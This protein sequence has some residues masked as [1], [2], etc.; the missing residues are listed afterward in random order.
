MIANNEIN[1]A[2]RRFTAKLDNVI[3]IARGT[4]NTVLNPCAVVGYVPLI[5]LPYDK[6][7]LSTLEGIALGSEG[8]GAAVGI[9]L[10]YMLAAVQ[11]RKK[12]RQRQKERQKTDDL[13]P[14]FD[15]LNDEPIPIRE[16]IERLP[17]QIAVIK[18]GG[19]RKLSFMDQFDAAIDKRPIFNEPG[20]AELITQRNVQIFLTVGAI[21]AIV[22]GMKPHQ[23]FF[24]SDNLNLFR[25]AAGSFCGVA[26]NH[27]LAKVKPP[28][29]FF[30]NPYLYVAGTFMAA[31]TAFSG[32]LMT[33]LHDWA[34]LGASDKLS[35]MTSAVSF[36]LYAAG[37]RYTWMNSRS[38][39]AETGRD[40]HLPSLIFAAGCASALVTN[41][42]IGNAKGAEAMVLELIM[43][44]SLYALKTKEGVWEY[45]RDIIIP[46]FKNMA[47]TLTGTK[48]PE[49]GV[50]T[51]LETLVA[52]KPSRIARSKPA[53]FKPPLS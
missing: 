38:K 20:D 13:K 4:V 44:L 6:V 2:S 36:V 5:F 35:V 21:T 29:T 33:F 25:V 52:S 39:I 34:Q 15:L 26:A 28:Y 12:T 43:C 53:E 27:L 11:E 40:P 14:L 7:T 9:V 17:L 19:L 50:P 18:E 3:Q 10:Y 46:A 41:I 22:A 45:T 32:H 23:D 24:S 8:Y 49:P 47:S 31:G 48:K 51:D 30:K 16:D 1:Q 37:V 42:A